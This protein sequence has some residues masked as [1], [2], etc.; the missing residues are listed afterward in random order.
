M[1]RLT[2]VVLGSLIVAL[3]AVARDYSFTYDNPSVGSVTAQYRLEYF[4]SASCTTCYDFE[5]NHLR[6]LSHLIDDGELRVVFRDL[7]NDRLGSDRA[8]T[9]FC[10]QEYPDYVKQRVALKTEQIG[11]AVLPELRGL[12]VARYAHCARSPFV[13]SI[14][15]HN[16]EDFE[17]AGFKGTPS[18]VL[19]NIRTRQSLQWSGATTSDQ[20]RKGLNVL[21]RQRSAT[22]DLH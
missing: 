4:S 7:P 5:R 11:L 22:W 17:R 8:V 1:S 3:P 18:F 12:A 2:L 14:A 13:Q 20:V 10:L 19:T 6:D 15:T 9:Q 21:I 16:F